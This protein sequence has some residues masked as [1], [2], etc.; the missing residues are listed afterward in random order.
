M[1]SMSQSEFEEIKA[2]IKKWLESA[3]NSALF[4]DKSPCETIEELLQDLEKSAV[5][6]VL[7]WE[8]E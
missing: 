1:E 3:Q 4:S 6:N 5:H 8:D 2:G 7:P